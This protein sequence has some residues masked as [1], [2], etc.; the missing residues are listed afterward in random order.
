VTVQPKKRGDKAAPIV[1]VG[2]IGM[3]PLP[4]LVQMAKSAILGI[5]RSQLYRWAAE[6]RITIRKIGRSS[7]VE[8]ESVMK[9]IAEL[10]IAKI[11]PGSA[12]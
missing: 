11:G 10:P 3:S 12:K 8:T 9:L 2:S 1:P 4:P 6:D 5:S 7:Y